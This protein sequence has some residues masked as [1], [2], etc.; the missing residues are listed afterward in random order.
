MRIDQGEKR[1]ADER[2]QDRC[3]GIGDVK[4]PAVAHVK[5]EHGAY[6]LRERHEEGEDEG[7]VPQFN[8]H[9]SGLQPYVNS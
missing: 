4:Q 1:K 2:E 5:A 8:D 7:E 3:G 6:A 9:G